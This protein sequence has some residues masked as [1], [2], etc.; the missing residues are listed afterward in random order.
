MKKYFM[1][2]V[3]LLVALV[4]NAQLK[5]DSVGNVGIRSDTINYPLVV[6]N[7]GNFDRTTLMKGNNQVLLIENTSESQSTQS[8]TY[9]I[10]VDA[11][12]SVWNLKNCGVYSSVKNETNAFAW[13]SGVFGTAESA[14]SGF[15]FGVVGIYNYSASDPK[16]GAGIYGS[17][18][19]T[20]PNSVDGKYAGYFD[21]NVKVYNGTING[22]L[23]SDSDERLK[24]NVKEL[25]SSVI[26][27]L[28]N[29]EMLVPVSYNYK[30]T[31]EMKA[32]KEEIK[33]ELEKL[34]RE[35][36][37]NKET[38]NASLNE[39][40][41]Q[42]MEKTHFGL[43]AQELQQIYPNLVYENDNGTFSINY[44]ELIPV[45]IQGVKELNAKVE[46]QNT[47]ISKLTANNE[48]TQQAKS[49]SNETTSV[50][51]VV[52]GLASMEQNVP[53]PFSEKTD[54]AIFLPES[55]KT[56]KLC[57][58]DLNGSQIS[59]QEVAGRGETTMTIHAD[60][61]EDGMYLYALIAD[62]KVVTTKKM[63]VSK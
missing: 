63:I 26:P 33:K 54:I 12:A 31:E 1:I 32:N 28:N 25:N 15:A 20:S 62:G 47:I 18:N 61:M 29:L 22:T 14:R 5:V 53:N 35:G 8:L 42:V 46:Q 57:I 11:I 9:G 43:M 49:Y 51:S 52:Q 58:Y 21:G 36:V 6:N 2:L 17:R 39:E 45:L 16:N 59:K 30:E 19:K 34:E 55:V 7:G 48:D 38:F 44:T 4:T 60:E 40:K 37:I 23:V 24:E 3:M 27:V 41:S 13:N 10:K 50:E 56:A